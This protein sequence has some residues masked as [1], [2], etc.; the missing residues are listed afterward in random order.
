MFTASVTFQLYVPELVIV[1]IANNGSE[2]LTTPGVFQFTPTSDLTQVTLPPFHSVG[3]EY[4]PTSTFPLS[5]A[6]RSS[7]ALSIVPDILER[8][9]SN[10]DL[11]YSDPS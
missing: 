8:S 11:S 10:K 3:I 2:G 5:S 4:T 9:K 7:S 6:L 1:S